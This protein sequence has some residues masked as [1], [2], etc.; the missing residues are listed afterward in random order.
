MEVKCTYVEQLADACYHKWLPPALAKDFESH[1]ASCPDCQGELKR[2]E[3]ELHQRVLRV[4]SEDAEDPE[5]VEELWARFLLEG[6][7]VFPQPK[8][9]S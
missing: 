3:L 8:S 4:L 2:Y 1:I 9:S 6:K 5:A 7:V